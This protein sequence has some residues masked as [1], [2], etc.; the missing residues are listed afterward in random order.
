MK[1]YPI[2]SNGDKCGKIKTFSDYHW[3]KMNRT[4]KNVRW[5]KYERERRGETG[6]SVKTKAGTG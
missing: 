3:E 5:K 4:F 2:D 6:I 1:A